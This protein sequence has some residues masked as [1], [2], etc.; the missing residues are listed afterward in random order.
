[1]LYLRPVLPLGFLEFVGTSVSTDFVTKRQCVWMPE[2]GLF[3]ALVLEALWLGMGCTSPRSCLETRRGSVIHRDP[4]KRGGELC[5][6]A[7]DT[8][9]AQ[10]RMDALVQG[11]GHWR[12]CSGGQKAGPE[13]RPGELHSQWKEQLLE[14]ARLETTLIKHRT[15]SVRN[16][17]SRYCS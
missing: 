6:P 7:K 16:L 12:P 5:L 10:R 13:K 4:L 8:I 15:G 11:T 2:P 9:K 1:M 3:R 14:N 17:C